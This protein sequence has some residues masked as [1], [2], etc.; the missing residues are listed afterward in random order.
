MIK[1]IWKFSFNKKK[2]KYNFKA[3]YETIKTLILWGMIYICTK[4]YLKRKETQDLQEIILWYY[5]DAK[6]CICINDTDL[7]NQMNLFTL[8]NELF[9]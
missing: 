7:Q 2:I 5:L 8:I 1:M 9:I 6:L 3:Y 4:I